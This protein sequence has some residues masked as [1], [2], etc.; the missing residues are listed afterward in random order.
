MI[1]PRGHLATAGDIVTTKAGMQVF[2]SAPHGTQTA[3]NTEG[4]AQTSAV[5]RLRNPVQSKG[6]ASLQATP[7]TLLYY[8]FLYHTVHINMGFP[9]SS[10]SKESAC[11][12]GDVG[13]IPGLG[14]SSGG[15]H[16]NPLQYSCLGNPHGQKS[17]AGY[18]PWGH[19]V[20]HS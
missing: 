7:R 9:S 12:V 14:R 2:H 19:R 20:G 16:G 5:P 3:Q 10:A 13:L 1:F 17:L 6:A 18:S 4:S 15:G 11:N 8:L